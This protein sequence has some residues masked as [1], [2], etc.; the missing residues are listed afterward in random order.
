MNQLRRLAGMLMIISSVTHVLQLKVYPLSH[1]VIGAAAFGIIYFFIG[2]F[3]LR[4]S[5]LALWLGAILPSISR[6]TSFLDRA[7][8]T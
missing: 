1:H 6:W 7:I 8:A 2:L 5:R 4:R 3:L